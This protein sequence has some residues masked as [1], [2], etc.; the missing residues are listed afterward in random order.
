MSDYKERQTK[1]FKLKDSNIKERRRNFF[2]KTLNGFY[3]RLRNERGI[4]L[5]ERAFHCRIR[6]LK[7][8]KATERM[9]YERLGVLPPNQITDN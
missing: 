7:L 9:G 2:N 4:L 5:V 8:K 1:S 6:V 3:K